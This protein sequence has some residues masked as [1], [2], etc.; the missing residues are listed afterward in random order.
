MRG[1]KE[2][3]SKGNVKA[4]TIGSIL[5]N[6]LFRPSAENSWKNHLR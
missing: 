2:E 1:D 3:I 6:S 4:E 5:K